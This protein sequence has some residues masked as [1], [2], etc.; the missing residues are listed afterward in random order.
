MHDPAIAR[1]FAID[2]LAPKYPHYSPYSF[3]GN[4]VIHR[5]ELEGLEDVTYIYK[6]NPEKNEYDNPIVIRSAMPWTTSGELWMWEGGAGKGKAKVPIVPEG[7]DQRLMYFDDEGKL[8]H[9]RVAKKAMTIIR[10]YKLVLKVEDKTSIEVEAKASGRIFNAEAKYTDQIQKTTLTLS[11]DG[12]DVSTSGPKVSVKAG[13][14]MLGIS[15]TIEKGSDGSETV[16]VSFEDIELSS[17]TDGNGNESQSILYT[18]PIKPLKELDIKA[19]GVVKNKVK[20]KVGFERK[21]PK[22]MNYQDAIKQ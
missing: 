1:F 12:A 16:S 9:D 14:G 11:E 7:W 19:M 13:G 3:S 22:S 2:P 8:L 18:L 21:G 10:E 15:E 6:F 5:I 17:K 4:K 20:V